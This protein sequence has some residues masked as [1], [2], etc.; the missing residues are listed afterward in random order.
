MS[1]G[2][3][4]YNINNNES[5]QTSLTREIIYTDSGNILV[6]LTFYSDSTGTVKISN[7][8]IIYPN[9]IEELSF[10]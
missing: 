10:F 8:D 2:D 7:I 3:Y 6:P 4:K 9:Q 5:N 1:L